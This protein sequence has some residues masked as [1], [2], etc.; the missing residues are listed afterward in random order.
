MRESYAGDTLL[1]GQVRW[2]YAG[3]QYDT[4]DATHRFKT[5]SIR[6]IPYFQRHFSEYQN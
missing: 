5:V 3:D 1:I 2:S 4:H 6:T